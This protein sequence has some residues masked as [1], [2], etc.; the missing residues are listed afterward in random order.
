MS[1]VTRTGDQGATSLMY[2]RRVSKSDP[3]VETYGSIDELVASLGV[4]R[5]QALGTPLADSIFTIQE[6][7]RPVMAELATAPEDMPRFAA[8][9]LERIGPAHIARLEQSVRAIEQTN[10]AFK[11]W[12]TPGANPLSAS[13]EMARTACRRAERRV[14]ALRENGGVPNADIVVFLN[15]LS[16]LLWLMAR[17]AEKVPGS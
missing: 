13:L 1:I 2:N 8:D 12:A 16:D 3:R 7:L 4:A 10:L 11:G 6:F 9:G 5:A 15:R 14:C 17:Q